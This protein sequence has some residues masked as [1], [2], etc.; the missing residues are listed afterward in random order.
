[1]KKSN[2]L[3]DLGDDL[4]IKQ[5]TL[6]DLERLAEYNVRNLSDDPD[7]PEEMLEHWT[8]DLMTNHH[9]TGPGD[10]IYA[11]DTKTG[12]IVSSICQIPQTWAYEGI[13]F[14][15]GR[16][17]MVS[18]HRDYRRKGLVRAQ[19]EVLHQWS[20]EAGEKMCAIT[21]IPYFYRQFGYEMTMAL[22]GNRRGYRP[23]IP[24]LK[25]DEVEP[26]TIREA[27]PKDISFISKMYDRGRQ[28]SLFSCLRD[29]SVW[30]YEMLEQHESFRGVM[31]IIETPDGKPVGFLWR[32]RKLWK[33]GIEMFCYELD[34]GVPWAAVTPSVIR[35]L[36]SVGEDL[37][38]KDE[39]NS[40]ESYSF[41]LGPTHPA[42]DVSA[43]HLPEEHKP[44]AWY[45]R[46]PDLPDFIQHISPILE[47]R[48]AASNHA[49]YSGELALDFHRDGLKMTFENGKIAAVESWQPSTDDR[50][51]LGFTGLS[52][53]HMFC[54]YR[55]FQEL[56]DFFADCY[57]SS[58]KS[59]EAPALIDILFPKKP[60]T[61]LGIV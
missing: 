14:K 19:F 60:S 53:L 35:H 52:F 37:A 8:R 17:E 46:I 43:K 45:I 2:I 39:K 7:D 29:E 33:S 11:E 55:S 34:S 58:K 6:E 32:G 50:G 24:K 38:S 27:A 18:T 26:Y 13:P 9:A 28:R 59:P 31:G 42:Y 48:L 44:Y 1:M 49:G 5:A 4:V 47:R 10:F 61:V 54:G 56:S 36:Q 30:R 23:H 12:E 40:W 57:A 15:V 41:E 22:G 25:E 21:G 3:R 16:Y 51:A 20:L